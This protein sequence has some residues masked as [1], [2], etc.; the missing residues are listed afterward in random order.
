MQWLILC[1]TNPIWDKIEESCSDYVRCHTS[2]IY[3]G[4]GVMAGDGS[5]QG[6]KEIMM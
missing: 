5:M 6:T 4:D 2:N 3:K 1:E